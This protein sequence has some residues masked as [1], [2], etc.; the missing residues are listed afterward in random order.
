[1]NFLP[2]R[3]NRQPVIVRGLTADE[4]WITAGLSAVAGLA[5][6]IM[7]AMMVGHLALAPTSILVC[8]AVASEVALSSVMAKALLLQRTMLTGSKE[9]NIAANE[10]AQTAINREISVLG[11]EITN[12]KTELELRQTLAGNSAS[13]IIERYRMRS[14]SSRE[15]YV[16]DPDRDRLRQI[17]KPVTH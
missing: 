12:L 2:H 3:L 5:L 11:Q 15:I 4:L 7:L 16:G 6:G 17:Q 13:Q 14:E 10:L 9:P 8:I 1:M